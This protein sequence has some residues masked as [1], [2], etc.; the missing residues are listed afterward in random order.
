[1]IR[2]EFK[3][4]G[5]V[6]FYPPNSENDLKTTFVQRIIINIY[7]WTEAPKKN[8][9]RNSVPPLAIVVG[10]SDVRARGVYNSTDAFLFISYIYIHNAAYFS[11]DC[12]GAQ[13]L[14]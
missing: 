9:D 10:I 14:V 5:V 11:F 13:L 3:K 12:N 7:P 1:M 4:L 8:C 6:G 2:E